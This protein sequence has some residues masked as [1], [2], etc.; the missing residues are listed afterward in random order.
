MTI[1]S[2]KNKLGGRFNGC[3]TGIYTKLKIFMR[4]SDFPEDLDIRFHYVL[5]IIVRRNFVIKK[6]AEERKGG[7]QG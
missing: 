7:A 6:W 5:C 4:K 1:T 3:G 2:S